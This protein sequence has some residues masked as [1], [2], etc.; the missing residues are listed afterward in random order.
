MHTGDQSLPLLNPSI[1]RSGANRSALS[2]KRAVSI[3]VSADV[4]VC[5]NLSLTFILGLD[6]HIG[7]HAV[8]KMHAKSLMFRLLDPSVSP[9]YAYFVTVPIPETYFT[10]S[11]DVIVLP[12]EQKLVIVECTSKPASAIATAV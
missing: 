12:R 10:L 9:E 11:D 3:S 5:D 4:I 7:T 8:I 1:R 6:V 2:V